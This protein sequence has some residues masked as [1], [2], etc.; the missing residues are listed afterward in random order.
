MI[1]P[2]NIVG[3]QKQI[4]FL[5]YIKKINN[6]YLQTMYNRY[7]VYNPFLENIEEKEKLN[8]IYTK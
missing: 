2:I 4:T 1:Y 7:N 5:E 6:I 3:G 8:F